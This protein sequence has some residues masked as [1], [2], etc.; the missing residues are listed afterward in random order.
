MHSRNEADPHLLVEHLQDL[1]ARTAFQEL[2]MHL[3][4]FDCLRASFSRRQV[5][6]RVV[7]WVIFARLRE[8]QYDM[9]HL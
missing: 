8:R 2:A 7:R 4:T 3:K 1:L 5:H 6:L 9:I